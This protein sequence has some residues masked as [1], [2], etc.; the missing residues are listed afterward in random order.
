MTSKTD[1]TDD[2]WTRIKRAPF[3][4]GM[5]IS[6]SDPGGPIELAKETAA[7]LKSVLN[8]ADQGD[9][10]GAVAMLPVVPFVWM[11]PDDPVA[12]TLMIVCGAFGTGGHYLLIAAHRLAPPAVL[13]PFIYTQIVWAIILGFLV[14]ADLPSTWTLAGA[15]IVVASGLYMLYREQ[16]RGYR[17]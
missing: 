3:V 5:A 10:V 11:T 16:M 17:R 1:F 13:A 9:F 14:F 7:T 2:E 4:A 15:A 8:A 6:F 12:I